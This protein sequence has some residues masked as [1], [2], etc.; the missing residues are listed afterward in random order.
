MRISKAC[1]WQKAGEYGLAPDRKH[2][3]VRLNLQ[4]FAGDAGER[5]EKA[6]PKKRKEAREKGQ[7]LQS[8][9][10]NSALVLMLVFVTIGLFGKF[11]YQGLAEYTH[12]VFTEYPKFIGE[13]DSKTLSVIFLEIVSVM[14]KVVAPVFI[15]AAIAG[16]IASYAQVGF[17]FT[18]KT[19]SFKFSKLN[20]LN[21]LKR[22]F[23][24]RS[25]TELLKSLFKI[26]VV[27]IMTYSFLNS[28]AVNTLNLMDAS[29]GAIGSYIGSTGVS[30]AIRLCVALILIGVFDYAYQWWDYEKNL[31]MSKQE[32][33]EEYKQT[34]GNP[35]IKSK[36]KQKQRQISM[37]RMLHDVP[38]ADVVITNPTHYA[39]AVKYDA[40][41]SDAP[42][43]VAKGQ[44][45]I[46]LRIKE[47]AKQ[48]NVE[49]VENKPL[50]RSLFD[51]VDVGEKIPPELYQAVAE[52]LAFV[53]G[54]KKR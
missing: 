4:L 27:G 5:T 37:R 6:T 30:L 22:M 53:Y 28:E 17:L 11:I 2:F 45:F 44:D 3:T 25:V 46:A 52:V 16:I 36:I 31:K 18:T 26:G 47:T 34:E 43:V 49:I 35:E 19:L 50:A 39:V 20:P 38:K 9:E 29:V 21:G 41:A 1:A 42:I 23:S 7:V 54:L 24:F 8:Q 33:K 48:N 40:E 13:L 51:T 14:L 10:I 32:I 12:K 15:V